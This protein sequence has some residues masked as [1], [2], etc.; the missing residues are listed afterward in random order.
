MLSNSPDHPSAA[1]P[2]QSSSVSSCYTSS[3]SQASFRA[4][5]TLSDPSS[6]STS[7]ASAYDRAPE[8]TQGSALTKR[9][10]HSILLSGNTPSSAIHTHVDGRLYEPFTSSYQPISSASASQSAQ[11]NS[12]AYLTAMEPPSSTAYG[13]ADSRHA[14]P[15]SNIISDYPSYSSRNFQSAESPDNSRGPAPKTR[16]TSPGGSRASGNLD[17]SYTSAQ[18]NNNAS[19]H[20]FSHSSRSPRQSTCMHP[21]THTSTSPS[22]T[23]KAGSHQST[24]GWPAAGASSQTGIVRPEDRSTGFSSQWHG[25]DAMPQYST[26]ESTSAMPSPRTRTE[27]GHA[28]SA[29]PASISGTRA[30]ALA[31]PQVSSSSLTERNDRANR[32]KPPP[33]PKMNLAT[34]ASQELLKILA[35][36]LHEI[37]TANDEFQPDGSKDDLSRS[38]RAA[39]SRDR[40]TPATPADGGQAVDALSM[41]NCAAPPGSHL[42]F[43]DARRPSVTTAALGALATPSST[44]CFHA[45][46]VPSISIE[47]YLLRILKYCPATNEVFLSLLVYFDRMSRMGTGAK[48]GANGDGEVAGEAAGLPRAVERATGQS[49]LGID[50]SARQ[51]DGSASSMSTREAQPYTHPGI[52]GF[53]IDSYNVH[54]LMIAGVTVASKFFSDVF[55]TN[56]RYAKVGGLPP[57]ELNQLELQFLLLNDFRLTIPL[58]E[59]QRY[60]DQLLM[61]ASGR[62][63]MV[64]MTKEINACPPVAE[65]AAASNNKDEATGTA[66]SKSASDATAMHSTTENRSTHG[67][68]ASQT[69]VDSQ[70]DVQMS[71]AQR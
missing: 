2:P 4:R 54:R 71:D 68:V 8:H 27:E 28:T 43:S 18:Y 60:A 24:G 47:S 62:Q 70:D 16:R 25:S 61:Y 57:H 1:S 31:S 5:P 52:R 21:T 38:K 40:P 59:M 46:N 45:R 10:S 56:S 50:A 13:T 30:S 35:T 19:S 66:K 69:V 11:R 48:F 34:F 33:L 58:E 51:S 6:S 14:G 42:S 37:A 12:S 53:A 20:S 22:T 26:Q 32:S 17:P 44:L 3:S 7:P 49:D 67:A 64:K 63:D 55:Y 29:G 23:H 65:R 41:H 9:P 39:R 36:L 15:S